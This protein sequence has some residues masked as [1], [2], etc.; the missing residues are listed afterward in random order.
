MVQAYLIVFV[1]A[2][3]GG[4]LRH[5]VNQAAS[6]WLGI[7]FPYGTAFVNVFGSLAMG[8]LIDY[9]ALRNEASHQWRLFLATGL[10]GG[11]TT[12]STYSLDV[13]LLWERG[14]TALAAAYAIGSTVVAIAAL[15]AGMWAMRHFP[16]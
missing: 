4:V 16:S 3:L 7:D 14:E 8:M 12:F 11:F 13:A 5:G 1:G 6:R 10:L 9:F 2:G 15:F